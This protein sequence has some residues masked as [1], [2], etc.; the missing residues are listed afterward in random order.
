MDDV[1]NLCLLSNVRRVQDPVLGSIL[2]NSL[3]LIWLFSE[4][5][6]RLFT[7]IWHKDISFRGAQRHRPNILANVWDNFSWFW[8]FRSFW[9]NR[10]YLVKSKH[11]FPRKLHGYCWSWSVRNIF[12][13]ASQSSRICSDS[14]TTFNFEGLNPRIWSV[15]VA[16]GICNC[17]YYAMKCSFPGWT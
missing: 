6:S 4:Y 3:Q 1:P 2:H 17:A 7:L 16:I 11:R 15:G 10:G 12:A 8:L 9:L 13:C 5:T 14:Q